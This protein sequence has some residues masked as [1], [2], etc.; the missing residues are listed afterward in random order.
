M[1]AMPGSL[2]CGKLL[3]DHGVLSAVCQEQ[4][5]LTTPLRNLQIHISPTTTTYRTR[6]HTHPLF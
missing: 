6:N 3:L 4:D 2:I 1:R 5:Q